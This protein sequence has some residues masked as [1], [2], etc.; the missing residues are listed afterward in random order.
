MTDS[1][2]V[3]VSTDGKLTLLDS[4][5]QDIGESREKSSLELGD[6][7]IKS[8]MLRHEEYVYVSSQNDKIRKLR[9]SSAGFNQIWC[10]DLEEEQFCD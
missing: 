5:P 10:Y 6:K 3:I 4:T 7:N 9:V 2:I 1:G 8:P